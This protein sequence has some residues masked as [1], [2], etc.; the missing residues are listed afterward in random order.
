V[1]AIVAAFMIPPPADSNLIRAEARERIYWT[2]VSITI[3]AW[4][5]TSRIAGRGVHSTVRC[6]SIANTFVQLIRRSASGVIT[7]SQLILSDE[8]HRK[9]FAGRKR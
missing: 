5:W 9:K 7:S 8:P 6:Q 4:I 1:D 3:K 2:N